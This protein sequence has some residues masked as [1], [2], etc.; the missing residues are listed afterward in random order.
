MFVADIPDKE[1][2]SRLDHRVA[3][4]IRTLDSIFINKNSPGT[5]SDANTMNESPLLFCHCLGIVA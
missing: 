1:N 5:D 2:E 3:Q 4:R